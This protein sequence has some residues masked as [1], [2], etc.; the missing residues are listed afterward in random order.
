M[1]A[2]GFW[3]RRNSIVFERNRTLTSKVLDCALMLHCYFLDSFDVVSWS[4]VTRRSLH[5]QGELKLNVD[6][7]IFCD[8]KFYSSAC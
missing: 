7:S 3:K 1:I 5:S 2:W 4:R 8:K 6:D